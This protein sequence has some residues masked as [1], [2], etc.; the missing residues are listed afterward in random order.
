[1][2]TRSRVDDAGSALAM[3]ERVFALTTTEPTT[4]LVR[5]TD[6][7]PDPGEGLPGGPILL[8]RLRNLLLSLGVP[9]ATRDAVWRV[10]IGRT[11]VDGPSWLVATVG[12]ALPGLRRQVNVLAGSSGVAREDLESA[13]VEGFVTALHRVDVTKRGL[14]G[15]LVRAGYRAGV[16]QVFQD[17]PFTGAAATGFASHAPQPPWGHPDFVLA[18][19]VAAGV[20]TRQ[21]AWLI[22]VTRL[23]DVP[24]AVVA[25]ELGEPTNTIVARRRRAERCLRD[26]IA[27]GLAGKA[28]GRAGKEPDP[29]DPAGSAGPS[30]ST[31]PTGSAVPDDGAQRRWPAPVCETPGDAV[32]DGVTRPAGHR[33]LTRPPLRVGDLAPVRGGSSVARGEDAPP[34]RGH[35]SDL[36]HPGKEEGSPPSLRAITAVVGAAQRR[37]VVWR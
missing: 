15:R 36:P 5:R 25:D 6:L 9:Q 3:V 33:G 13:V 24:V 35:V 21:D 11:R 8:P 17:A 18:D 27:E 31:E 28:Q 30:E 22:G 16:R 23:E 26:A 29:I 7:D 2:R 34:G 12:M 20:L 32:L 19:A 14:C 1:M 10:L 4:L 37:R